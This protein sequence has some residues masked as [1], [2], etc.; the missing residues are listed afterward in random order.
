[1]EEINKAIGLV[2]KEY[3]KEYGEDAKIENDEEIVGVLNDGVII[4]SLTDGNL[5][6]DIKLG[7]PYRVDFNLDLLEGEE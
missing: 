6:V 5:K 4:I 2:M 1:M 3:K 7:K